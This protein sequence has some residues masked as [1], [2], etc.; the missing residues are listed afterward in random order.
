MSD[1]IA[2]F[3]AE[4][5]AK[6]KRKRGQKKYRTREM[7]IK[8]IDAA[9]KKMANLRSEASE[10]EEAASA[11]KRF[12]L[13]VEHDREKDL[14]DALWRKAERLEKFRLKKLQNTLAAFDTV[15]LDLGGDTVTNVVLQ[16]A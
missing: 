3:L 6:P 12:G 7:V 9:R 2:A 1:P 15:A 14:A 16:K 5:E 11:F 8:D 4:C 13:L 10:C